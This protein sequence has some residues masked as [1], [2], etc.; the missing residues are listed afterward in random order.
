MPL[1]RVLRGSTAS[2]AIGAPGAIT[3]GDLETTWAEN[4][5]GDGHGEFVQ[6]N[7]PV[8]VEITKFAVTVRP[9]TRAIAHGVGPRKVWLAADGKL[10]SVSFPEDP[11]QHAGTSYDVTLTT[12]LKTSCLA[13]VLDEAYARGESKDM[14]VTVAEVTALSPFDGASDLAG[15][16]GALAG[17]GTRARMAAAI[18]TRGGSPAF[19][20]TADGYDKLDDAGRVLALEVLDGAPCA[21]SAPVYTR[22]MVHGFPGESHHAETRLSHC[23]KDA[24]APLALALEA[25]PDKQRVAAA[26][27]LSLVAPP[28]AI[29]KIVDALPG[30]SKSLRRELRGALA[31]AAK[32][33][34]ASDELKARLTAPQMPV[35]VLLDLLRAAADRPDVKSEASAAFSRIATAGSD[36]ATRYLLLTP[37]ARLSTQGD[38]GA[39]TFLEN[40]L[41]SD[42]DAHVR[43]RAAEALGEVPTKPDTALALVA[44]LSDVDP[45]VR[46]A[47]LSSLKQATWPPGTTPQATQRLLEDPWTFVRVHAAEALTSAP[48]GNDADAPLGRA[49]RDVSPL[50]RAQAVET[51]GARGAVTQTKAVRDRL[52][53]EDETP[54][55]RTRAAR[56]LGALCD[57]KSIDL[58]TEVARAG[59]SPTATGEKQTMGAGA[60][61]ALGRLHPNDLAQRL[62]PLLA[63]DAARTL[64]DA[65]QA[66]VAETRRCNR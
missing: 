28:V 51:L 56:A 34:R 46:D 29:D 1:A 2:S 62:A 52:E 64:H 45:R 38:G 27:E 42:Q 66:A 60:A 6:M 30:A 41:R 3:D 20:L 58:L 44:G 22:A 50:V 12:P 49:L 48:A 17:G 13:F 36:F 7:A 43:A 37:A 32:S 35:P 57:R 5:G 59:A 10:F 14:E 54:E 25:G 65:A 47:A 33:E 9:P 31:T 61:A 21:I 40:A 26:Q 19:Q 16:V 15:L 23:G 8:D 53:D 4:R 24:V 11:W 39:Q 18:L 63:K 55:V